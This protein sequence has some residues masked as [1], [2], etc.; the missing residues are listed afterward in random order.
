MNPVEPVQIIRQG[1]GT[2]PAIKGRLTDGSPVRASDHPGSIGCWRDDP[3]AWK[4]L[5]PYYPAHQ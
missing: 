5:N 4:E 2:H 1:D 3:A